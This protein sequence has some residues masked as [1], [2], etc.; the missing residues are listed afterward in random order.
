MPTPSGWPGNG[1]QHAPDERFF[2][3][4]GKAPGPHHPDALAA[5]DPDHGLTAETLR[6]Q[7]A[8]RLPW[9]DAATSHTH[10]NDA[11]DWWA[12]MRRLL[13][14]AY[15]RAGVAEGPAQ[16]AAGGFGTT[17]SIRR[18]GRSTR[19]R[20]RRWTACRPPGTST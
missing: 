13:L 11:D 10:L 19:I 3:L 2:R 14:G 16:R 5:V 20:P 4:T 8:S 17:T 6:P 18:I 12:A 7:L 1:H 9:H 15:L